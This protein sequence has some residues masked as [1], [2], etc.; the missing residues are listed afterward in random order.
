MNYDP[1]A[2]THTPDELVSLAIANE[3]AK[4]PR[5]WTQRRQAQAPLHSSVKRRRELASA[6]RGLGTGSGVFG[7]R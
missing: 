7:Y 1:T 6:G 3:L 4:D 2:G 5:V